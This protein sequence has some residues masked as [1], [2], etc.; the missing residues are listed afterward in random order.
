MDLGEMETNA[1]VVLSS[2]P[3]AINVFLMSQDFGA[4]EGAASNAIFVS[5]FLSALTVPL[6]LTILGVAA[7]P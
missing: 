6:V 7:G 2:L 5:T 1:C 4:E 3:V